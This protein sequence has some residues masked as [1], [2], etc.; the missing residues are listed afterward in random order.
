MITDR[1]LPLDILAFQ[2]GFGSGNTSPVSA[3]SVRGA[4]RKTN[5][6]G[7][8]NH[9]ASMS[10]EFDV[11]SVLAPLKPVVVSLGSGHGSNC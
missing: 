5:I 9:S 8:W 4:K 3:G 11:E 2:N 10:L 1:E 6:S 7:P